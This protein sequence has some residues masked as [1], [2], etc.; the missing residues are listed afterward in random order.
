MEHIFKTLLFIRITTFILLC[1][2]CHFYNEINI[3]NKFLDECYNYHRRL[4]I[5]NYRLLSKYWQ[6]KNSSIVCLKE[7]IPNVIKNKKG[8]SNKEKRTARKKQKSYG[9]SSGDAG[10]HKK[11]MKNNTCIFETKN[12]SYLE[13][14]IFKELD[15]IDFLKKKKTITDRLYKKIIRKKYSLRLSFP[16]IL[17]LL[18]S[19][20]FIVEYFTCNGLVKVLYNNVFYESLKLQ[21]I[22]LVN[23]IK[24]GFP[25][26]TSGKIFYILVEISKGDNRYGVNINFFGSL[27]Y[28]LPFFILGIAIIL[29]IVYYHKKVKKYNKIKFRRR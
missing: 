16:V 22:Q 19:V 25:D 5:S 28:I 8:M 18:L 12:Y 6:N 9:S 10:A 23:S 26:T 17:L 29:G 4:Y 13:K 11:C 20:A 7:K 3:H 24:N 14:K 27:V 15:Y 2:I 21:G 1:W